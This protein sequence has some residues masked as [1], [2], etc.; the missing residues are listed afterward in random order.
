LLVRQPQVA[1]HLLLLLLLVRLVVD[2]VVLVVQQG[3]QLVQEELWG[4]YF[5]LAVPG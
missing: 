3:R 1:V 4:Y 2:L 5:V